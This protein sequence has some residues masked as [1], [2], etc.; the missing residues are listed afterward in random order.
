M[1]AVPSI[2]LP[3]TFGRY[4][5]F[6]FI[7]KVGMAEI[8]LARQK[9]E[10]GA[11]RRCVVKQILPELADH[12]AFGDLLVHEAK[13]AAR[14]S[15]ANVVQVFDLG[16]A[17]NRLFIAMEYVEGFD[18]NDLLRRCARAKEPLPLDL[19]V[20]VVREALKGLDYAHRRKDDEGKALGIVHRDVSPSNLLVSFEGEVK[21][22]DF[23]IARAND[24]ISRGS[25]PHDLDDALK[26]KAG[27]MSPEHAR[28]DGIDARADVFAAGIVLW[29]LAA[30]RRMYKTGDGRATLLEQARRAEVPEL[31]DKGLPSEDKL[32][33]VLA[34]ALAPAPG[35]RYASAAAMQRALDDYVASAG[36]RPSPLK[37][38]EWL[39]RSFGEEILAQRRARE[40]AAAALER[41]APVV[42]E[43]VAASVIAAAEP[44]ASA[45]APAPAHA[46][47]TPRR[48]TPAIALAA[49]LAFVTIATVVALA[50]R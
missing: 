1:S 18:L 44:L 5:I 27:Y 2:V 49:A 45:P 15:H 37:L 6:D 21:V 9:T 4:V 22:C 31:P 38:G 43:A 26:G 13:L 19:A 50:M 42:L 8:Y 3:R 14:L 48:R 23:G 11:A 7:G 17:D 24:A 33:A 46:P 29:E 40:R 20:H 32:R 12:S 16:R 28:G 47:A 34:S 41:G 25:A 10:L 30:G 35:D 39:A 36:L